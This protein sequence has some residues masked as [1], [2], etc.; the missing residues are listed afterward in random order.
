[1]AD[2][3]EKAAEQLYNGLVSLYALTDAPCN[4]AQYAKNDLHIFGESA[5]GHWI[6]GTAYKIL[7]ENEKDGFKIPLKTIGMGNPW[8]DPLNQNENGNFAQSVGLISQEE[9]I[10]IERFEL[11]QNMAILGEDWVLA[12]N[13]SGMATTLIQ[14]YGGGVNVYNYRIFGDYDDSK[15]EKW[16]NETATMKYYQVVD[17]INYAECNNSVYNNLL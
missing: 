7:K 13:A 12:N 3:T 5:A 8:T 4:F 2:T 15:L 6:P 1:M 17:N 11:T 10:E 9:R 14:L 16:L